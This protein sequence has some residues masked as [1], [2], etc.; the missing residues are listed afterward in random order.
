MAATDFHLVTHWS[1]AAPR[2]K[3]WRVLMTPE[4]WPS[5]WRA[6]AKVERLADGDANGVGAVRRMTWRTALP[7]TLTFNMR[8]TR[9]EPMTTI[10]GRAE[11]ELDGM[12]VWTLSGAEQRTDIRYDWIVEVT[13]PW[14]RLLAPVM[15]PVFTWNH[16]KVMRWGFDGLKQKLAQKLA[17]E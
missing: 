12:G 7:Y 4:D 16:N 14:Q 11:G 1:I 17:S 5:W 10:E 9:I 3:V 6:V 15:R 13:K 8:M 2:E